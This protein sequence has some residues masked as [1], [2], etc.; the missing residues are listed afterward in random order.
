LRLKSSCKCNSKNQKFKDS[1]IQGFKNLRIQKFKDSNA[2]QVT[3][4]TLPPSVGACFLGNDIR[5]CLFSR[6]R[7]KVHLPNEWN[8]R[9]IY[10]TGGVSE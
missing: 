10:D 4:C 3:A 2:L 5:F 7:E 8:G 1:K 6:Y 9:S